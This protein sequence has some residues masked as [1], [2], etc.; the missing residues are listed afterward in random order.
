M[1]EL[2]E[3]PDSKKIYPAKG[4]KRTHF[5]DKPHAQ[6]GNSTLKRTSVAGWFGRKEGNEKPL[7]NRPSGVQDAPLCREQIEQSWGNNK[8]KGKKKKRMV[9]SLLKGEM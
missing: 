8:K 7:G 5:P 3:I 9:V 4:A 2:D 6:P 1:S